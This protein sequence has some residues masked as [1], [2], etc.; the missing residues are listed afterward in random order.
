[1]Q[2]C[3]KGGREEGHEM[4]NR[5][6]SINV[7]SLW[8]KP[9]GCSEVVDWPHE[10]VSQRMGGPITF[11]GGIDDLH[12]FIVG[13]VEPRSPED[14][15]EWSVDERIFMKG[16]MKGPVLCVATND[17]GDPIDV[18]VEALKKKLCI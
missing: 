18:D 16:T 11:V 15:E 10:Q 3:N 5:P 6:S 1:M 17:N 9:N 13:L 2:D 4:K 14:L 8:I 7:Q 12:V